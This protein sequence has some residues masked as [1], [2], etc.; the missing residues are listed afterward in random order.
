MTN[1][2]IGMTEGFEHCFM[3]VYSYTILCIDINGFSM[4]FSKQYTLLRRQ[5][6][7]EQQ[8]LEKRAEE[9]MASRLASRRTIPVANICF[10][11]KQRSGI[12]G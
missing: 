9:Q 5:L 4:F 10:K 12:W 3:A 7:Q 8:D 6:L 2:Y 1:Q 11:P